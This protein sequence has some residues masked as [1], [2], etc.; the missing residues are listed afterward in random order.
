MRDE[1]KR[2]PGSI[3]VTHYPIRLNRHV[4]GVGGKY[5]A[6]YIRRKEKCTEP[7]LANLCTV[8]LSRLFPDP[9]LAIQRRGSC[10]S[11]SESSRGSSPRLGPSVS[12]RFSPPTPFRVSPPYKRDN[13]KRK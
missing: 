3:P 6:V 7:G 1:G 8:V 5:M 2:I 11:E 4:G 12:S 13:S 9:P 10:G